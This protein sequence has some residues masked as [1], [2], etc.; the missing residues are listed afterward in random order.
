MINVNFIAQCHYDDKDTI[1]TWFSRLLEMNGTN[2]QEFFAMEL[3]KSKMNQTNIIQKSLEAVDLL[4]TDK[5][6]M[7]INTIS[8]LSYLN[9]FYKKGHLT[10][11]HVS[12]NRL[13]GDFR[14]CPECLNNYLQKHETIE[15]RKVDQL[16]LKTVCTKHNRYLLGY[17]DLMKLYTDDNAIQLKN[18]S[19]MEIELSLFIEQLFEMKDSLNHLLL[20]AALIDELTKSE[21][22][23]ETT[24][25]WNNPK[26]Q[27]IL[28]QVPEYAILSRN[29][30]LNIYEFLFNLY[31][32]DMEISDEWFVLALFLTFSQASK[33]YDVIQNI[34]TEKL[35]YESI[36]GELKD[37]LMDLDMRGIMLDKCQHFYHSS[38]ISNREEI[39]DKKFREKVRRSTNEQY[40]VKSEFIENQEEYADIFHIDCSKITTYSKSEFLSGKARCPH[41]QKEI[42][43]W[44]LE[45]M[46]EEKGRGRYRMTKVNHL[47]ITYQYFIKDLN[48]ETIY[49]LS[50]AELLKCLQTDD[51]STLDDKHCIPKEVYLNQEEKHITN[52]LLYRGTYK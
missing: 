50:K 8:N 46:V 12:Q 49:S 26:S 30:M 52:R 28:R 20:C 1:Y 17:T 27:I 11:N 40:I 19:Q 43:E 25:R 34:H 9:L 16:P 41:C 42:T 51:W 48:N 45:K 31:L 29:G 36:K 13:W 33:L 4:L 23:K 39:V 32:G 47:L 15:F 2:F 37:L 44:M 5:R 38:N 7:D 21:N 18:P 10:P 35:T 3:S 6:Q 14:I 22:L 24:K